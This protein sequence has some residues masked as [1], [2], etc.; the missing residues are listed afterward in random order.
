MSFL[1][2]LLIGVVQG[3]TEFLPVSSSGHL[4]LIQA[5][6]GLGSLERFLLFDLT[7]HMGTLLA[8]LLVFWRDIL[9]LRWFA[10]TLIII[11]TC[12]LLILFP[13]RSFFTHLYGSPQYLG[14][15]FLLTALLLILGSR[16]SKETNASR[17]RKLLDAL[18][19]GI[20]QLLAVIPGISRSGTTISGARMLGWDRMESAR[21][22]FLLAIPAI[23]GGSIVEA[24]TRPIGTPDLGFGIYATGFLASFLT[25]L[26]ALKWLLFL[27]QR[28]RLLHF[29]WYCIIIGVFS[30]IYFNV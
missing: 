29:A 20:M 18:L 22:S 15:F 23:I 30:L 12:P 11:G 24:T 13:Y 9:S 1:L 5:L 14:Y 3:L 21:F 25:G 16:F 27:V 8:I 7:C 2:A 19:I 28:H 6:F 26:L 17:P 4:K 10:I